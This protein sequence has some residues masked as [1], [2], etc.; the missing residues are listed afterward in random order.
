MRR[1][2][3]HVV[4]GVLLGGVL[5]ATLAYMTRKWD[6]AVVM[7]N[8][9]TVVVLDTRGHER[10]L[11]VRYHL[12]QMNAC[13]SWSQHLIYR[14][15]V[16]DGHTQRNYV[17]LAITANGIG[18]NQDVHDFALSFRL[19]ADLMPGK[20]WYTVVTSASC[21]WLPGLIRPAVTETPPEMVEI[22]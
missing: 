8:V 14:D 5:V 20:W 1:Y 11:A 6:N 22:K 15:N 17:P 9:G 2:L 21:E 19:P 13:P 7:S 4:I 18:A 16:V 10:W 3:L 12:D